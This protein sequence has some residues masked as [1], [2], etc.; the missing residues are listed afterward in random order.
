MKSQPPMTENISNEP[1][2]NDG[3]EKNTQK[4]WRPPEKKKG[5]YQPG[6]TVVRPWEAKHHRFGIYI[7]KL[8][9]WLEREKVG[10]R[11]GY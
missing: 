6:E 2:E 5:S 1:E 11:L 3:G 9:I 10:G 8:R 7:L 4:R